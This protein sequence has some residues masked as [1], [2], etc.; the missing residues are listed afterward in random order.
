MCE[1]VWK[2]VWKDDTH[3][4]LINTLRKGAKKIREYGVQKEEQILQLGMVVEEQID[5]DRE[6]EKAAGEVERLEALMERK[7]AH[8]EKIRVLEERNRALEEQRRALE[9]EER[10]FEAALNDLD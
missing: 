3:E 2:Q 7:R 8:D 5:V 6:L 9:E 1:E 4:E 10:M